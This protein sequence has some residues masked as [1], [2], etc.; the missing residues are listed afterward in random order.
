[1]KKPGRLIGFVKYNNIEYPFRFDEQTFSLQLYPPTTDVWKESSGL[2]HYFLALNQNHKKHEWVPKKRI[3][4]ITSDD[5]NVIFYVPD[6]S[7]SYNGFISFPVYWYFVYLDNL[8]IEKLEGFRITG[9]DVNL[10]YPPQV[11]LTSEIEFNEA[12][13]R[14]KRITVSSTQHESESCGKYRI[15]KNIDVDI[16]VTAYASF[17]SDTATN[18]ICANSSMVATFSIPVGME[19]LIDAYFNFISFFKYITYRQN[20]DI[21]DMEVFFKNE[22]GLREYAGL[23]VFPEKLKRE[24]H[25]KEKES[26]IS[27]GLLKR[28]SAKLFTA[29]KNHLLGFEHL[30][31][32]IDD[33][34]HYPPSR[35]IMILGEFEREYRN[36]FGQDN[37]RSDDYIYVKNEIVSLINGF[38]GLQQGKKRQYAKQIKKYVENR[39]SSFEANIKNALLDN[40]EILLPFI[41]TKYDSSYSDA[42]DGISSRM[43]EVRNGIAHS[44]LDLHFDAIHLSDILIIEQLIYAMRLKKITLS[45]NECKKAINE[46]FVENIA[47]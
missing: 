25:K 45:V 36:I 23:L 35:I 12:R 46:L 11:A 37:G 34:R 42:V 47:L 43:G 24:T 22:E 6:T 44:H 31:T 20:I 32:S 9:R 17:H 1:M 2:K 5:N 21:G 39:D 18:P 40:E 26:I 15:S 14:L 4:G 3:D 7:T 29:I 19:V 13:S 28:N 38:I 16:G 27:Y 8:D 33:R 41:R 30:C 10:F